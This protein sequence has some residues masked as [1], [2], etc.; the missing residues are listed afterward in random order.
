MKL[1][2]EAIPCAKERAESYKC[3]EKHYQESHSRRK[4]LCEDMFE[5]YKACKKNHVRQRNLKNNLGNE[6]TLFPWS[7]QVKAKDFKE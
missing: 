7:K 1:K 4:E 2:K 3:I 5:T 6:T